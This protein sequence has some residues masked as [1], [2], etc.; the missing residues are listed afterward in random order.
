MKVEVEVGGAREPAC[1]PSSRHPGVPRPGKDEGQAEVWTTPPH[2]T[3]G[4]QGFGRRGRVSSVSG[5]LLGSQWSEFWRRSSSFVLASE[6]GP[7]RES[8]YGLSRLQGPQA[9]NLLSSTGGNAI[10]TS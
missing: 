7:L 5:V 10:V 9:P 1:V 4:D 2:R 6:V 3:T 8:S